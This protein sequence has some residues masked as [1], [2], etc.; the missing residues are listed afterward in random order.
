[1]RDGLEPPPFDLPAAED[2][3]GGGSCVDGDGVGGGRWVDG[4][5]VV[6]GRLAVAGDVVVRA[7]VDG[8]AG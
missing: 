5:E 6:G 4:D 7:K 1:M 3:V 8:G 2:G